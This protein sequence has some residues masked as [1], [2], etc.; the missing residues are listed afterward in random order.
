[1]KI[2][3]VDDDA[4]SAEAIRLSLAA[5]GF[6]PTWLRAGDEAL[7]ALAAG[8]FAAVVLDAASPQLDGLGVLRR[9]RGAGSDVPVIVMS[10]RGAKADMLCAL[11]SGADDCIAKPA[12]IDELAAR[13]RALIRRA[14][15]R[16][17]P[18]LACGEVELDPAAR[19]AWRKGQPVDL[20]ARELALLEAL[21]GNAGR[22]MSRAQLEGTIY[23]W[24]ESA[25]SNTVEVY[26]HYL[27]KKFGAGFIRTLRGVG[28]LIDAAH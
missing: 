11:D 13:F 18:R 1:M 25:E 24:G 17:A 21:M 19:R 5:R 14:G 6:R 2:L 7:S 3:L 8:A 28:Y 20:S 16:S 26:V 9:L 15:G 23:G 10:A 22:V 27:R 4:V 12:D